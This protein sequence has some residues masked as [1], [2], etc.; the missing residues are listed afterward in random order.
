MDTLE[1]DTL[2]PSSPRAKPANVRVAVLSIA[3]HPDVR[4]IGQRAV[5]SRLVLGEVALLSRSEPEFVDVTGR[6]DGPL[7]DPHVS[8]SPIRFTMQGD[9]IAIDPPD[10]GLL[11]IDGSEVRGG[12]VLGAPEL[13]SGVVV[14]ISRSVIVVLRTVTAA[15]FGKRSHGLVGSSDATEHVRRGIEVAARHGDPVLLLGESGTG[16]ERIAAA[17]HAASPRASGP[18]VA[19]NMATLA[20]STAAAELFGHSRGAFTGAEGTHG[21]YFGRADGGTLLLDEIADTPPAVQPMLLRALESGEVEPVGARGTRK[22][23]VR[24]VAATDRDLARAVSEGHF[25]LPLLHRLSA[26]EILMAPLRERREDVMPLLTS[27]LRDDGGVVDT[28]MLSYDDVC[29]L[30]ARPWPGNV[31]ELRNVARRLR[32]GETYA[33]PAP[34][35]ERGS[36]AHGTERSGTTH[37]SEEPRPPASGENAGVISDE[38]LAATLRR[39]GFQ[40]GR[41]ARDLGIARNTLYKRMERCAGLRRGRDLS[42]DEIARSRAEVGPDL[43]HVAAKLEVSPRALRLRM[44]ELGLEV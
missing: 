37:G 22:V 5:L 12:R 23:D 34:G 4:R 18:F 29:D 28:R 41:T 9:A 27:F 13:A 6:A 26:Q 40:I 21:G 8:R 11:E 7:R 39:N 42:A 2:E 15:A 25:R 30:L 24:V 1:S 14:G 44:R 33:R 3:W 43:D 32:H 38:T 19:V 10:T 36:T 17:I 16:K 35:P 31:R 20:P